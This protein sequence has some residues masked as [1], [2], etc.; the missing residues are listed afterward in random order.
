[1]LEMKGM[2]G[3]G[4]EVKRGGILGKGTSSADFTS[5]LSISKHNPISRWARLGGGAFGLEYF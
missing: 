2:M 1:M 4:S 3:R 5:S